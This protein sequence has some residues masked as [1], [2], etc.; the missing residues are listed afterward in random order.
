MSLNQGSDWKEAEPTARRAEFKEKQSGSYRVDLIFFVSFLF[1]DKKEK[2]EV[3]GLDFF[4]ISQPFIAT[5]GL[6]SCVAADSILGLLS[7]FK[8]IIYLFSNRWKKKEKNLS[9][10]TGTSLSIF[11]HAFLAKGSAVA[12][13]GSHAQWRDCATY[14][15]SV[16]AL[17]YRSFWDRFNK[18]D[19]WMTVKIEST[20]SWW[21]DSK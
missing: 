11:G 4:Y 12:T 15:L 14:P 5:R 18:L 8:R 13:L 2:K 1:Q 9:H 16:S 19:A 3:W 10:R 17:C 20:M 21:P 7:L 6:R